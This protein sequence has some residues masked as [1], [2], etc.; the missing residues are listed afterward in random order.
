MCGRLNI[1][2]SPLVGAICAIAGVDYGQFKLLGIDNDVPPGHG[3]NIIHEVGGKRTISRAIWWLLL[4]R[5]TLKPNYKYKSFN[6]RSDRL[7][8]PRAAGY[9]PYRESRCI[10]PAQAFA[11]GLGDGKTYYKIELENS[12]IAFGGLFKEWVHPDTGEIIYSCSIITLGPLLPQWQHIHPKSFPLMLP[13]E[14]EVLVQRWLSREFTDVEVFEPLLV[15]QVTK[16]QIVTRINRPSKWQ[17][18]DDSFFIE[19]GSPKDVT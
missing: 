19:P 9:K 5:D 1:T 15:P 11:E 18:V 4:D 3:I 12:A 2:D 8:E 13:F 14:D 17:A 7:H 10:I 6:T 16:R